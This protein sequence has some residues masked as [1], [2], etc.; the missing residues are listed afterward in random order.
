MRRTWRAGKRSVQG[1]LRRDARDGSATIAT[2]EG[3]HVSLE[4][5]HTEVRT[6][7][8]RTVLRRAIVAATAA[9][10]AVVPFLAP[11]AAYAGTS[12]SSP[13]GPNASPN[14][15]AASATYTI[16]FTTSS[17]GGLT[18]GTDAIILQFP[19]GT[20]FPTT[21]SDYTV[22]NQAVSTLETFNGSTCSGAY[23]SSSNTVCV[24]VPQNINPSSSVT[25]V[26]TGVTNPSAGTYT[27]ALVSTTKDTTPAT[28]PAYTIAPPPTSVTKVACCAINTSGLSTFVVSG[29][30][31]PAFA[32]AP[33]TYG[34]GFTTSTSGALKAG[35]GTITI[36]APS[37]TQFPSSA[38]DYTVN[39][40]GVT[41]VSA[42][43]AG[44]TITTP[45]AVPASGGVA[46]V[47][48]DVTNP[49]TPST[50]YAISVS[51]SGDTQPASSGSY[52]IESPATS[53][54]QVVCCAISS[55][56]PANGNPSPNGTGA[57]SATYAIGFTTS[58]SGALAGG[59][60][61]IQL[62]APFGTAFPTATSNYT[63][64]GVGVTSSA[65]ETFNGSSCGTPGSYTTASNELCILVPQNINASSPVSV[66]ITGV[67][68]PSTASTSDTIQVST[69][70]DL[71][72]VSTPA[73]TIASSVSL[74]SVSAQPTANLQTGTGVPLYAG[75]TA[76]Y[77]FSAQ[78]SSVGALAAGKGTITLSGPAGT[79]FPSA[80]SA[81]TV[82][83]FGAWVVVSSSPS[84]TNNG[85]TVT[86]TTPVAIA[87]N[88]SLQVVVNG[89][90]NPPAGSQT[91][92]ISTSADSAAAPATLSI[93]AA[94]TPP[95]LPVLNPTI[96]PNVSNANA[97]GVTY[98]VTFTANND[99]PPSG[100]SC[101]NS[102]YNIVA[103]C[104]TITITASSGT[105]DNT[106]GTVT[107]NG[108]TVTTSISGAGTNALSFTSPVG[109]LPG[110]SVTITITNSTNPASGN[111][112]A[113]VADSTDRGP[114][115][116]SGAA[117]N[118]Y[119]I[120]TPTTTFTF[121]GG[122]V[123]PD[124]AGSTS[125]LAVN[126][127]TDGSGGGGLS[128]G[129]GAITLSLSSDTLS[130]GTLPTAPSDYVVNGVVATSVQVNPASGCTSPCAII[131]TPVNVF[132]LVN[133]GSSGSNSIYLAISGFTNPGNSTGSTG[134]FY[135][136][137]T[138]S[139]DPSSSG[140]KA[141]FVVPPQTSISG[142]SGPN[143]TPSSVSS[144]SATYTLTFTVSAATCTGSSTYNLSGAG[145][146]G[147]CTP[148]STITLSD[149]S[150][151]T[152]FPTS[153][154]NYVV[155][156][157]AAANVS[158]TSSPCHSQTL[159]LGD[160]GITPGGSVTLTITGV[161]NPSTPGSYSLVV[162]TSTDLGP[163]ATPPYTIATSPAAVALTTPSEYPYLVQNPSTTLAG[164]QGATYAVAFET[165]A[166]G[167]LAAGSG[168]ITLAAPAGTVLP[169]SASSYSVNGVVVTGT[170]TGG[171]TAS[172]T[173]TT[174]VSLGTSAYGTVVVTGVTNPGPGTYQ[175]NVSTS[176]DPI[177][178]AS[179]TYA[180][181]SQVSNLTG[182][183]PTPP[184]T[185]Q[186]A[187]YTLSFVTSATGALTGGVDSITVTD[188]ANATAFP[189]TSSDYVVNGVAVTSTL[190]CT[191]VPCHSQRLTLPSSVN[192]AA[193]GSVT[194]TISDVTNPSTPGT[195]FL[196][197]ST[198][199]DVAPANTQPY[200]IGSQVTGTC[201][202][203][204]A[205]QTGPCVTVN[206]AVGSQTATYTVAFTTST[207][208]SLPAGGTITLAA[209]S[210][211]VWPSSA[212]S[213]LLQ[214]GST[215]APAAGVSGGGTASV[216]ITTGQSIP[217]STQVTLTAIGVT[218]PPPG[219]YNMQVST[220]ADTIAAL[221]GSYALATPPPPTVTGVSPNGGSSAG[222]TQVTITGTNFASGA[223]VKFGSVAA[224]NVTVNS[225]T[226][227]TAV[228]PAEPPGVVDVTVTVDGQTSA[229]SSSDKFT[230]EA[231]YTAITP[232]RICDTRSVAAVGG[233]S[234]VTSG[235]TGQCN[236][237]GTMLSAGSPL[238][239]QV[240]GLA[241]VPTSGVAAVV[242]NVT[243][244]GPTASGFLTVWPA[245][246][247]QPTT[248][249][250]N[251]TPND[252]VAN[253]VEVGLGQGGAVAVA[254]GPNGAATNVVVDVE[255]F[256]S[257]PS[258]PGAG[259]YNALT[260]ARI[261]D[262]RCGSSPAPSFC[263]GENLPAANQSL[264]T[265]QPDKPI[266][267]QVTG[268]GGVPSTGVSAVVLNVTAAD[269]AQP[270][271]VT[272]YP[273]GGTAPMASNI[274]TTAPN[275][276]VPNRVIVPVSSS[277]TVSI[278]SN[279]TIDVIVDV[280]GYFTSA[281]GSGAQ[282]AAEATPVRILDTRCA[283]S[284]APSFCAS[285]NIPSQNASIGALQAGASATVTVAGVAGVPASAKAVVLNVTAT[286]TTASSYL[287]VYPTG[288]TK[289]PS[290]DLNWVAGETVPNLVVA[291][292]GTG[293]TITIFNY[294]GVA[295]VVVDVLGW[296]Q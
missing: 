192:V 266:T 180:I 221:S 232:T 291:T 189:T 71:A 263:A 264:T 43:G 16:G 260:P 143:P 161:T 147:G 97:T 165:S 100:S 19:T 214:V 127:A 258:A 133:N 42:S 261:A 224:T 262:T 175:L 93:A 246:A 146:S 216:T 163:Q 139:A 82:G 293:G 118:Y 144:T 252:V 78:T 142:L 238:T 204:V 278:V 245:G 2:E 70:S 34:V 284:P 101:S 152:S 239:V 14:T 102:T 290:S 236:N 11:E 125:L 86:I 117:T 231:A 241:G 104:S 150:N 149:P 122:T 256:V 177:P 233:T 209:P 13:S 83:P 129:F 108:T 15:A 234:D 53:V 68:N 173:F 80:A 162:Y 275:Q 114:A 203:G 84:V 103:G 135:T 255:G 18:G 26:I 41:T 4:G 174:P 206:P 140:V 274:N 283:A 259:L 272:V 49:S 79:V 229:T 21:A 194:L 106:G 208:G 91:F 130:P 227:I 28:L 179:N 269:G 67:T 235:V 124:T 8:R 242:L 226:S 182:P 134:A 196:Q 212:S 228:S 92:F 22:N 190:S 69:S 193:G 230:Y 176:A 270:A 90:T 46:V 202:T 181:G 23:S 207:T 243:A 119:V 287:T 199:K 77:T 47:I 66:V 72:P 219:T 128:A 296:Y 58:S 136:A 89:V 223:I 74:A 247:T 222:G 225:S 55:G 267:V 220:S 40:V 121:N 56:K 185:G 12:V 244:V 88:S 286:D 213:Y 65:L 131:T 59:A 187:T 251:F 99:T 5:H 32:G 7:P 160:V 254:V 64:N 183:N 111:Y 48:T 178:A 218:N 57:T 159:T 54:S 280:D 191:V 9:V 205:S 39:G 289:P 29:S 156:G 279:Q 113:F 45:V 138:T 166:S 154:A 186:A 1:A 3:A 20:S 197:V 132:P 292:V 24:V 25:L 17:S 115:G 51:T 75:A 155:N 109:V 120:G 95:N 81:Y 217:A 210:G 248:S 169:S 94:P 201:S 164:A 249:N 188:P 126:G 168:T 27:N 116:T 281:G 98:T 44:V 167:A 137:M 268:V 294:A 87:A 172:V 123:T 52:T 277:G 148:A 141:V 76:V 31:A 195:Y 211:T 73:Y 30:P 288:Q 96:T 145:V 200:P 253:L 60:G 271:Y 37:G 198:S 110:G 282:F 237:S 35:S 295:D 265:L 285:E 153:A 36:T 184:T 215:S 61:A 158:C 105:F 10:A 170:I 240:A 276:V 107:I 63:V 62:V 50:A 171:G 38:S 151:Q 85:A 6:T 112:Q 157:V 33:A 250:L 273:G 257:V